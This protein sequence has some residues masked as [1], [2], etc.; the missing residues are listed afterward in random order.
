MD[1]AISRAHLIF[2]L[3]QPAVSC[4]LENVGVIRCLSNFAGFYFDRNDHFRLAD[5]VVWFTRQSY[6]RVI[7]DLFGW[8]PFTGIRV[9]NFATG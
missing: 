6:E 8:G 9:N 5:K 1:D 4:K 3:N 2:I 7:K